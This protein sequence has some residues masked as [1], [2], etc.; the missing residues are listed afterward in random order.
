M[1]YHST[2]PDSVK[3]FG[4]VWIQA[5]STFE[6]FSIGNIEPPVEKLSK[7]LYPNRLLYTLNKSET[8]M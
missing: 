7:A 3:D 8:P 1:V 6:N 5:R 2:H 4:P